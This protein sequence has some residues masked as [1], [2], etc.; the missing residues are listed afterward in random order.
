MLDDLSRKAE[1]ASR[2]QAFA[3]WFRHDENFDE[4]RRVA[5]AGLGIFLPGTGIVEREFYEIIFQLAAEAGFVIGIAFQ[6][7]RH[8]GITADSLGV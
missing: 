4:I 3:D 2:S 5:A 6:I 8:P 1:N 7:R